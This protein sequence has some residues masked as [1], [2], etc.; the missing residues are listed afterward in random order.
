MNEQ[1]G[2]IPGRVSA[3]SAV[4]DANGQAR[5]VYTAPVT[6]LVSQARLLVNT[7]TITAKSVEYDTEDMA[8]ISFMTDK[9]KVNVEPAE[10]ISSDHGFVP[11]DRRYPAL[12]RAYF[13]DEDLN[14]KVNTD[15]VFSIAGSQTVGMLRTR[16]GTEGKQLTVKTD[17]GGWASVNYFYVADT[18]REKPVTE[19]IEIRTSNMTIPLKA[20]VSTGLNIVLENAA[21]GY[22]SS[23]EVNA[24]DEVPL[25]I[26]VRDEWNKDLDLSQ[27]MNYWGTGNEAG[28]NRLYVKL[29]IEKQGF[30]PRYMLD[31]MGSENFPEPLYEEL[32]YPKTVKDKVKNLLYI[33]EY[34]LKK[35]GFPRVK[36][37]FSGTN[38]YEIRVSL[39]DD[40]GKKIF[41]SPH[42]R[43]TAFVSIPTGLPAEA[44]AIWFASNP[45]GPHTELSRFARMLFSLIDCGSDGQFGSILSLVDAAF[46]INSGDADALVNVMLSEIKGKLIDDAAEKSQLMGHHFKTYKKIS[47]AE[48]YL[49]FAWTTYADNGLVAQMENKILSEI[50]RA[51]LGSQTK[52]VVLKGNGEQ[53]LLLDDQ[54]EQ[55][56]NPSK[57]FKDNFKIKISGFDKKTT[58]FIEKIGK[59]IK[60]NGVEIPAGEGKFVSDEKMKTSSL[61][62]GKV[63]VFIIPSDMKVVNENADEMKIY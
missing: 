53:K 10:G 50:A 26:T 58:E 6:T 56:T 38:N 28:N 48:Q 47:L 44:Y 52:M 62:N 17:A 42:P 33:P 55:G 14:P 8:Y 63:S 57:A 46:A 25:K 60:P 21:S 4:T 9:G 3:T 36:P 29:E 31:W 61:K 19:T 32:L 11:P 2:I 45:L 15:V 22:E 7:A 59:K 27:I 37:M 40:K 23:K 34:S 1:H 24:G 12:I 13:N 30:V 35:E 20:Y 18:P 16:E 43:K 5:V 41:E 51:G 39:V 54:P 49:S